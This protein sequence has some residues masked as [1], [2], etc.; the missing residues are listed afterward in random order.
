MET[1]NQSV[2]KKNVDFITIIRQR[3]FLVRWREFY[4]QSI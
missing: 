4:E 3:M 1:R 2:C